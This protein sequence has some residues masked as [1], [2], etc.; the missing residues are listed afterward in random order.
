MLT[1][2]EYLFEYT[3]SIM[4]EANVYLS[5]Y[6]FEMLSTV[7]FVVVLCRYPEDIACIPRNSIYCY[8]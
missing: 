4:F 7:S 8:V 6:M 1:E 2:I 3:L 5:V